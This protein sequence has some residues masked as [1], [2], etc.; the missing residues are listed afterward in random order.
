M[1]KLPEISLIIVV[2]FTMLLLMH[3]RIFTEILSGLGNRQLNFCMTL[4]LEDYDKRKTF[5]LFAMDQMCS[6]NSC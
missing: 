6:L 1:I 5:K 3:V 4:K 2:P